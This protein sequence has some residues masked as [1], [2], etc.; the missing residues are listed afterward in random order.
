MYKYKLY[1]NNIITII[2]HPKMKMPHD[3]LKVKCDT[4]TYKYI[5]V[6]VMNVFLFLHNYLR[7]CTKYKCTHIS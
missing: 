6:Y 3:V 5:N 2:M 1:N 4:E 7:I